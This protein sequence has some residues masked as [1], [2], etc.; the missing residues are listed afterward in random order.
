MK[1][2]D[3]QALNSFFPVRN[4][5]FLSVSPPK[6]DALALYLALLRLH[7][8]AKEGEDVESAIAAIDM[9]F[10][11]NVDQVFRAKEGESF[12]LRSI[13]VVTHLLREDADFLKAVATIND[14]VDWEAASR[15]VADS[16]RKYYYDWSVF[17]LLDRRDTM[18]VDN[19]KRAGELSR[20]RVQS[21]AA[22]A[23]DDPE[24]I[25]ERVVRPRVEKSGS[26]RE[27]VP[28]LTEDL[29]K[30]LAEGNREARGACSVHRKKVECNA[31]A[32]CEY[33][34]GACYL[35]GKVPKPLGGAYANT[36]TGSLVISGSGVTKADCPE[37]SWVTG[38]GCEMSGIAAL[39]EF[40]ENP[41][42]LV[43]GPMKKYPPGTSH[44]SY[45]NVGVR[46]D[47]IPPGMFRDAYLQTGIV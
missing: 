28:P 18:D 31:V 8:A 13:D 7:T 1:M 38:V 35:K 41:S 37:G 10:G 20:G 44:I 40:V 4:P 21:T 16:K 45:R 27:R 43:R 2:T 12:A 15:A 32:D 22:A 17:R 46:T 29:L 11:Y 24:I 34:R 30:R 33:G 14:A 25:E 5:V 9:A 26:I 39:R 6:V 3:L 19:N 23:P 42:N 47:K 36:R